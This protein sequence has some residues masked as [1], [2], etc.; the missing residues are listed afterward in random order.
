MGRGTFGE[1]QEGS[2]DSPGGPGLV[3]GL[4]RRSG[5]GRVTLE[6]VRDGLGDLR[7][8]LGQVKGR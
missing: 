5:M 3:R 1:V 6:E 8:G 4:S 7:G 2:G